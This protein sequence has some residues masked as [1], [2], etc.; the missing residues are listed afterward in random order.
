MNGQ[1]I[2]GSLLFVLSHR[3]LPAGEAAVDTAIVDMEGELDIVTAD[4][5]LERVRAIIDSHKGPVIANLSGIRFCD[6]R[7]LRALLRMAK[8]A[9]QAGCTFQLAEPTPMVIRLLRVTGL[10]D[11][12]RTLPRQRTVPPLRLEAVDPLPGPR[13]HV[14]DRRDPGIPGAFPFQGHPAVVAGVAEQGA[15]LVEG[16]R[17]GAQ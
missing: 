15:R 17:S 8:Y 5:A 12:L 11:T 9:E 7:G 2:T 4:M 16:D 3:T 13:Q 14:R 1:P 6:A 10:N